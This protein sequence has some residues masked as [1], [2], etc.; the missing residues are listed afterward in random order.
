[1]TPF[2]YFNTPP[3]Y[4]CSVCGRDNIRLWRPSCQEGPLYCIVCGAQKE[5]A[6]I[7]R[8]M[9]LAIES[10]DT[11][12]NLLPAVPTEDGYMWGYTSVPEKA[13]H[14]WRGLPEI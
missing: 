3:E 12:G 1:M 13:I 5:Q 9:K 14:W 6:N 2:K 8:Y 10:G 11:I 7:E 4:M